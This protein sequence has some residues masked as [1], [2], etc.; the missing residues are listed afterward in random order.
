MSSS[1][2][3]QKLPSGGGS[4][5]PSRAPSPSKSTKSGRSTQSIGYPDS[6]SG[7]DSNNPPSSHA[8][9]DRITL[10]ANYRNLKDNLE[11]LTDINKHLVTTRFILTQVWQLLSALEEYVSYLILLPLQLL[12]CQL[13]MWCQANRGAVKAEAE[14]VM[15]HAAEAANAIADHLSDDMIVRSY[16]TKAAERE[17]PS[18]KDLAADDVNNYEKGNPDLLFIIKSKGIYKDWDT[19]M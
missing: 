2:S 1:D 10:A 9:T 15:H 3:S 19:G 6:G 18:L 4:Q 13:L 14:S 11:S 7:I 5:K 16:D 17:K 8:E 12:Y